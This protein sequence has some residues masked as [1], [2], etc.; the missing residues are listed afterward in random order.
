MRLPESK[1]LLLLCG[2]L[3]VFTETVLSP[4]Y[5]QFF[6]QVF[7]QSDLAL[8]GEY[9][10][11]CRLTVL[12]S[13]PLWGLLARRIDA[14]KLL[15]IGQGIAAVLTACLA[16]ADQLTWFF[17]LTIALLIFKSSYFLFY[18]ALIELQGK[19]KQAST[20]G[21]V[22]LVVHAALIASTLAS[23]WVLSFEHPL[24][25]FL[26]VAALDV[27]Q[28]LMCVVV[29]KRRQKAAATTASMQPETI[30]PEVILEGATSEIKKQQQ[31]WPVMT[32]VGYGLL[33][34]AFSVATNA[35]RPYLTAYSMNTL[36]LDR[37]QSAWLYL[38]P[39]MMALCAYPLLKHP[40]LLQFNLSHRY[41]AMLGL[42]VLSLIGQAWS[43]HIST[44][45]LSRMLFG[46]SMLLAQAQLEMYLFQ[47]AQ[48]SPHWYFSL[49]S[50]TQ[51]AGQ[52][53]APL[54]AAWVVGLYGLVA[55][56]WL[57]AAV[58]FVSFLFVSVGLKAQFIAERS[59]SN[60]R[61]IITD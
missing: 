1:S 30:Q 26:L 61:R 25:L 34:L 18:S 20:V 53:V 11:M 45:F 32:I 22:Q 58:L 27:V 43:S 55:P 35:V 37:L 4:F 5:P 12:L 48:H 13:A 59:I 10:A 29:L 3:F 19:D 51:H 49:S 9:V 52:L 57:A 56:F 60:D 54:C 39:S 41:A 21:Q 31:P 14:V 44:L 50:T 47:H 16:F 46:L 28:V 36:Q 2:F 23:A 15:V 24:Q 17:A 42:L 33:I 8:T 38:L 6:L 40:R 7:G